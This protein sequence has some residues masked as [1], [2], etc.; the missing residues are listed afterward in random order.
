MCF[1]IGVYDFEGWFQVYFLLSVE[2]VLLGQV[3]FGVMWIFLGDG[4]MDVCLY[5]VVRVEGDEFFCYWMLCLDMQWSVW[6]FMIF[7]LFDLFQGVDS[8]VK[9]VVLGDFFLLCSGVDQI[10]VLFGIIDVLLNQLL[11]L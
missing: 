2:G 5:V 6:F 9:E 7:D 10:E 1:F 4:L 8:F 11:V 3:L